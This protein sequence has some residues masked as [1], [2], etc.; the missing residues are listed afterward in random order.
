MPKRVTAQRLKLGGMGRR[1]RRRGGFCGAGSRSG[2]SIQVAFFWCKDGQV[3]TP[4]LKTGCL[5][6]TM[7]EFLLD[8]FEILQV[9]ESIESL[10]HIDEIFL[11]SSGIGVAKVI[12]FEN[13][14]FATS[15]IADKFS[16][17]LHQVANPKRK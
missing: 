9:E 6:G 12:K 8:N 14:K 13:R 1:G 10:Q 17:I 3:F 7:R 16:N 15:E 5:D 2:M 11:T 4:S